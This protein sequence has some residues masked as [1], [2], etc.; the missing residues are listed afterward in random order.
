MDETLKAA[1]QAQDGNEVQE[2][3]RQKYAALYQQYQQHIQLMQQQTDE[4]YETEHDLEDYDP[5]GE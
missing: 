2:N 1:K 3:L 5:N 4:L